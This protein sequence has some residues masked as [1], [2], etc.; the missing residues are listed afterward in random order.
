MRQ[1][2]A[3]T[4]KVEYSTDQRGGTQLGCGSCP[5]PGQPVGKTADERRKIPGNI[6]RTASYGTES[7]AL[8]KAGIMLDKLKMKKGEPA[9]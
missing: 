9:S 4:Y 7:T 1:F 5:F 2:V 8:Q 6:R 3:P